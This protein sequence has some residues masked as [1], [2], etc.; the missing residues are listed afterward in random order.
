MLGEPVT[1][2]FQA[3]GFR[4]RILSRSPQ[5]AAARFGPGFEILQ[6]DVQ[7]EASLVRAIKGCAGVHINLKGGPRPED[8]ERIEVRGARAV[9]NAA[10]K[11]GVQQITYLS[12]YTIRRENAKSPS[13]IA[14][15]EAEESIRASGIP[16][17]IFRATWFMESLP[18]FV[19]GKQAIVPGKQPNPLHW[20]AAADYAR[21]VVRSYQSPDAHGKELYTYGP[22]AFSMKEALKTYCG[23]VA[24]QVR[25]TT[26]PLWFLSL[27]AKVSFNAELEDTARFMAYYDKYG[28]EGSSDEA[29]RLLGAPITTLEQWCQQRQAGPN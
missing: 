10:R 20:L 5:K 17:V 21:M 12:A 27:L 29:N 25:V 24:P 3:E 6:G 28:E 8:Y 4:V 13:T 23:F 19:Q 2:Q 1:R 15:F 9:I 14:K 7:D 11:S 26:I 18:E 16:Y 22:Q